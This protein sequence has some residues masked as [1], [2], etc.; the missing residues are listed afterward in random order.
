LIGVAVAAPIAA[1][2]KG[3]TIPIVHMRVIPRA[4]PVSGTTLVIISVTSRRVISMPVI[5]R[6]VPVT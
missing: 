4:V 3:L 5:V 2:V 1:A 6:I